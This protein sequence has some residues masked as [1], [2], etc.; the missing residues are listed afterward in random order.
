MFALCVYVGSV[1]TSHI[2]LAPD[3]SFL[4]APG[5]YRFHINTKGEHELGANLINI[6]VYLKVVFIYR[7]PSKD[8]I[9]IYR[10]L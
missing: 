3:R 6:L 8:T 7:Q 9:N 5:R 1:V 10:L 4:R 2:H